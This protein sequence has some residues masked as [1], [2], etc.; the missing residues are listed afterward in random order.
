[1]ARS[2]GPTFAAYSCSLTSES[3][4]TRYLTVAYRP[5]S[6]VAG[7]RANAREEVTRAVVEERT[8]N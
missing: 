2:D 4:A 3:T 5:A 1:V 7:G 8:L 6:R